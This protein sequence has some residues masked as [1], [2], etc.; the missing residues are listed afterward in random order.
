[1]LGTVYI[2]LYT[3]ATRDG[4]RHLNKCVFVSLFYVGFVSD[5]F[6]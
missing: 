1:M 2:Q 6:Y 3:L 5:V 4:Y